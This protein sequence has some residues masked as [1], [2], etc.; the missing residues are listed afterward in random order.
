MKELTTGN[1]PEPIQPTAV[2]TAK[3]WRH[4]V[5][6][7]ILKDLY[8]GNNVYHSGPIKRTWREM[9]DYNYRRQPNE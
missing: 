9:R 2:F 3:E 6:A 7:E 5:K 8:G 1:K 4:K